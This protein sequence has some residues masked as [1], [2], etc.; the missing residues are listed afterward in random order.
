MVKFYYAAELKPHFEI[1]SHFYNLDL[2]DY[3]LP[4]RSLLEIKRT[5]NLFS[6]TSDSIP[7]IVVVM[8][9]PGSSI[10]REE[11]FII[12][13]YTPDDYRK[14]VDK[15][16]ILTRP[17]NAQYQIMRLMQH[18]K[19]D[20]VRVLNLSDMRNGNSAN[21]RKDF[22][23]AEERD[24]QNTHCIT[25]KGREAELVESLETKTNSIIA[26]W[27]DIP[28]LYQSAEIML[29]QP[30]KIIGI[31]RENGI[32]FRF[33]SPLMKKMKL[34]WLDLIQKKIDEKKFSYSRKEG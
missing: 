25:S 13:M 20:F 33:A 21:M 12:P 30:K 10:P 31:P 32:S 23:E 4:C 8:M 27:G 9:N 22:K 19:W 28:E 24:P 26:A 3:I 2:G 5:N 1:K 6:D 15:P 16:R 17:D 29:A 11:G 14:G 7:D 18:N 34:E